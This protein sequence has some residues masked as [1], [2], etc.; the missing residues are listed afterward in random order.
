MF[1]LTP[2][3]PGAVSRWRGATW[4][5]TA[6]GRGPAG[7]E[8]RPG[9]SLCPPP[10]NPVPLST[11]PHLGRQSPAPRPAP[12]PWGDAHRGNL[13]PA[14]VEAELVLD[15]VGELVHHAPARGSGGVL[16]TERARVGWAEQDR[17][18]GGGRSHRDARGGSG[19]GGFPGV[20][21]LAVGKQ[22]QGLLVVPDGFLGVSQVEAG[23]SQPLARLPLPLHVP[24]EA[25]GGISAG[26][27][28]RSRGAGEGTSLMHQGVWCGH[29]A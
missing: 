2:R 13:P 28:R 22:S 5:E 27:A 8:G 11:E 15:G 17:S 21:Y 25:K 18:H 14:A 10:K 26:A 24:W 20:S 29:H 9:V 4:S 6:A 19:L 16:R 23:C 12:R 3:S 7:M 1:L